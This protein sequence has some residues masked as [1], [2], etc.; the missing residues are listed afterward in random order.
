MFSIRSAV[1]NMQQ[2][3]ESSYMFAY[4][5]IEATFQWLLVECVFKLPE[6][7]LLKSV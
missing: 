7:S 1:G 5:N 6:V 3:K 2:K 4:I